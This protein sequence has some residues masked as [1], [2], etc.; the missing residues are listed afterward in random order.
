MTVQNPAIFIQSESH[1]AEDWR[2]FHRALTGDVS[3]IMTATDLAV[4]EKAGTADMSVDVAG[5]SCL[6]V[7]DETTTQGTYWCQ[8]RGVTNLAVTA[9]DA[10]NPRIDLVVARVEDS[11]YSGG[12]DAWS[13]AVIAGTPAG[14]PVAPSAP[15]NSIILAEVAVAALASSIVDAN[16]TD[17]R[18]VANPVYAIQTF[19]ASGSFTKA[20]Y[21]WAKAVRVRAV[22][23]GGGGGGVESPAVGEWSHSG[24]GGG[25]GYA[26]AALS[27]DDLAASET[28]TVGA[29]G[30]GGAAGLNGG[31]SGGTSSFGTHA[32]A[33]GGAGGVSFSASTNQAGSRPGDG[34]NATAGDVL[35]RG[36]GGGFGMGLA[37]S[38][39]GAY[40]GGGGTSVLGGGGEPKRTSETAQGGGG[41][42]GGGSGIAR[43]GGGGAAPGGDGAA[44]VVIVEIFG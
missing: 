17:Q 19:T 6:I 29:A 43:L 28:V 10:T 5:G 9:S 23:G 38:T 22:G 11:A 13:L 16:I 42:G 7:G 8:N 30:S 34:G 41:Y 32:V 40:G 26:E 33:A 35:V 12:T 27:V 36:G 20:T 44:G 25:G 18:T 24:G 15:S 31:S 1:P 4:T 3:G 21:P 37:N 14:S 2:E 39:D